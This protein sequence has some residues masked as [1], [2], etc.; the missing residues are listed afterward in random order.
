MNTSI[1]P[2]QCHS[3]IATYLNLHAAL[4]KRLAGE[5]LCAFQTK[6]SSFGYRTALERKWA[7]VHQGNWTPQRNRYFQEVSSVL[8]RNS[9]EQS[10]TAHW[11]SGLVVRIF[12]V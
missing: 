2:R 6:Q 10:A 5:A 4:I 3:I 8:S 12:F 1:F 7:N 9:V 11:G